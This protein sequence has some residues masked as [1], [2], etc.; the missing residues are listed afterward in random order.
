MMNYLEIM[1]QK[2]VDLVLKC[3]FLVF[4]YCSAFWFTLVHVC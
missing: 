3:Q 4:S 2:N 1:K